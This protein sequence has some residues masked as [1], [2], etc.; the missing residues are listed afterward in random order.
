MD[1]RDLYLKIDELMGKEV[2][3]SGW[4]RNHRKQKE[5]GFIDFSDGTDFRHVQLVYTN[6]LSDFDDITKLKIGSAIEVKGLISKSEGSGQEFE[7]KVEN[8]KLLG[9]CPDD[10]PIQPLNYPNY[11]R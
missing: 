4:I 5:F 2:T 11:F 9:D 8:I 6:E 1:I 10:Y 7:V 3:L